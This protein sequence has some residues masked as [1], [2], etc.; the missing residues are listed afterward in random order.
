MAVYI[1]FNDQSRPAK[2]FTDESFDK[3]KVAHTYSY[4][5]LPH[6]VVAVYRAVRPVKRNQMG[7]PT[8]FEE[9]GVFGPSAWFSIQGDRFTR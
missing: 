6:G 5:L 8:S 3:S 4:E 1:E 7:D 9:I 2:H